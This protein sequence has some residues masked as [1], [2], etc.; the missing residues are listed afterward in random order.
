MEWKRVPIVF[1]TARKTGE[2][3]ETGL[4]AGG[5]D[6]IVKPY[7]IPKLREPRRL[8]ADASRQERAGD[9]RSKRAAHLA[10]EP[11]FRFT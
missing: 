11:L 4:G 10:V 1:L 5:N 3:V 2:D 7:A 9:A 8:L 6:F